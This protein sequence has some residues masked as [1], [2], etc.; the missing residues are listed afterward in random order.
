MMVN[1]TIRPIIKVRLSARGFFSSSKSPPKYL[2]YR[3]TCP[4]RTEVNTPFKLYSTRV[5]FSKCSNFTKMDTNYK[6]NKALPRIMQ[7]NADKYF[8]QFIEIV[9]RNFT[10]IYVTASFCISVAILNTS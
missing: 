1:F 9:G 6:I 7:Y 3:D 2:G 8:P 4:N 5:K 10:S